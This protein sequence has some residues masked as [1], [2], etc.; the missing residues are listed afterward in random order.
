ML[1]GVLNEGCISAHG[2]VQVEVGDVGEH[3]FFI[4]D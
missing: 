4:L 1:P 2:I 3:E